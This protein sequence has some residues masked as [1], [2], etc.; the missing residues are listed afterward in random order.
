MQILQRH[1]EKKIGVDERMD[2]T[3]LSTESA[4]ETVSLPQLCALSTR[5]CFL[6]WSES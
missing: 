2:E 5:F 4:R 6:R 1:D 3:L